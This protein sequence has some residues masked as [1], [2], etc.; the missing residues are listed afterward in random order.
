MFRLSE[1]APAIRPRPAAV[2]FPSF[3]VDIVVLRCGNLLTASQNH[4][5]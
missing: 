1:T 3:D 5:N 2:S 4:G